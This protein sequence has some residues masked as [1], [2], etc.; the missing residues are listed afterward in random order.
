MA[1]RKTPEIESGEVFGDPHRTPRTGAPRFV[2]QADDTAAFA[3]NRLK[4]AANHPTIPVA[5]VSSGE[6]VFGIA[7]PSGAP[8]GEEIRDYAVSTDPL[9]GVVDALAFG[10]AISDAG[11]VIRHANPALLRFL[12]MR[13]ERVVG[14]R[15]IDIF[16]ASARALLAQVLN[17]VFRSVPAHE[18]PGRLATPTGPL[19]VYVAAQGRFDEAR[20]LTE[21]I[22]S[23]RPPDPVIPSLE[24]QL[25]R[26]KLSLVADLGLEI[27]R[28][29]DTVAA[30]ANETMRGARILAETRRGLEQT[31]DVDGLRTRMTETASALLRLQQMYA[32]LEHLA[33]ETAVRLEPVDPTAAWRR[34]EAILSRSMRANRIRVRNEMPDPAPR[35]LAD[36]GR[37]TEVFLNLL[38]NSRDA[39][40]RRRAG[41][42][43]ESTVSSRRLIMIEMAANPPYL[44]LLISNNGKAFSR[45]DVDHIFSPP[46]VGGV[47]GN[48]G[49]PEA[50][51]L[52]T[53]MGAAIEYQ[54]LGEVG[55]RFVLTFRGA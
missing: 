50:A 6:D 29:F 27:G 24:N 13:E 43:Q 51:A 23:F 48:R 32:E 4:E 28:E 54:A 11:G 21:I 35:V 34:A 19:D 14:R 45:E 47:L 17:E 55:V 39:I 22:W 3:R 9:S 49:L 30:A 31:M 46:D 53:V 8:R 26:A 37:L 36:S 33:A 20:T 7:Q 15:L 38:L 12:Q 18:V 52:L 1:E 42:V 41:S 16:D 40:R 10:V 2:A 5:A 25:S 44:L